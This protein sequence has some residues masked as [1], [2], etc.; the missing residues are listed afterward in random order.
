MQN[1]A[2]GRS[3]RFCKAISIYSWSSQDVGVEVFDVLT[4]SFS[5]LIPNILFCLASTASLISFPK[6]VNSYYLF[7]SCYFL[8]W[9]QQL[10]QQTLWS[11]GRI[12][13]IIFFQACERAESS[14]PCNLIG[15]ESRRYFTILPANPGGIVGSFIHKFV[16]CLWMSKNRHFQ[17]IFLLKLA[18]LLALARQI[19]TWC[20]FAS[21]ISR[22]Q[23]LLVK[24]FKD[25]PPQD[26]QFSNLQ[27]A[28]L[29]RSRRTS[30]K[31]QSSLR[32]IMISTIVL[33]TITLENTVAQK[34]HKCKLTSN[35]WHYS[36]PRSVYN[37]LAPCVALWNVPIHNED[38]HTYSIQ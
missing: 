2:V 29:G 10:H 35:S 26:R 16:C 36:C 17:T 34:G 27:A 3:Q 19:A 11:Y 6:W 25:P 12:C 18:L 37:I 13:L 30:S 1:R 23:I 21:R 4:I 28:K 7:K 24:R 31:P 8:L 20:K 33:F 14:K 38:I 15:S 5:L 22:F 9:N 32:R